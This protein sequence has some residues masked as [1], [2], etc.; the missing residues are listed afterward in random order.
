VTDAQGQVIPGVTV[1]WDTPS[2][3]L[4]APTSLTNNNGVATIEWTL[5]T[6]SGNQTAT[7]TVT[8]VPP[9][10]F[11]VKAVAGPISQIILSRDTVE[12]LGVGDSFRLNARPTDQFGNTVFG[13]ATVESS[14]TSIVT[15]DNFGNG[16]ILTARASNAKT[17]VRATA[18]SVVK[19]GTVV[20]LPPPCQAGST[21][22]NLG[23]GELTVLSGAE[24]SEFCLQGTATGAEFTAIPFFSDMSGSL[25]RV[26]ISTGKTTIGASPNLVAASHF[27]R[28]LG[29]TPSQPSRDEAFE[30]NLREQSRRELTPLMPIARAARRRTGGNFNLLVAVP[31]VGDLLQLNTNSTSGCTNAFV[32]TGRIAAITDRAIV[33]VDTSNPANGF[34]NEDYR[35]FGITFDTLVYPVD[36]QNFGDPTDIDQNAHVI[37]FFTRAVNELTPP[38]QNFYV[39]GFFYGRDLFPKT[40]TGNIAACAASNF[41]EMFYLMVPDP[42]GVVNQNVRTVSFV[43]GVTIGT[44]AHEFQH[45]INSSRHLYVN[46]STEFEDVFL[47]EGLAH[48]AEELNFYH[49]S[50]LSPGQNI[51]FQALQSPQKVLDAFNSFGIAN[52]RRYREFLLSPLINSPYANN[53]NLTTRGATWSF[54]RYAADRRGGNET[55]MWFQLANP[56]AGYRGINNLM[57]VL[58]NDLSSWIRDWATAN[59]AD[60]FVSGIQAVDTDPSWNFRSVIAMMNENQFPLVTQKLDTVS[61]TTVGI[62]DGAAAYLRFGVGP[63]AIGGGRVT[64]RGAPVPSGFSLSIL[65]TK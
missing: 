48:M 17:T 52:I 62:S 38:N 44:L 30:A 58:G 53:A 1:A 3:T 32:R 8:R 21:S 22:L 10:T 64:S 11:T 54:L 18:G 45:L 4:S 24:A 25:L 55:M 59:Y 47:D 50:G 15:A 28:T 26:S 34:T 23:I 12:L 46:G 16:A 7:A 57:R 42:G 43:Q 65:R 31:Q 61:I 6:L 40:T 36:T 27:Q 2:G 13:G 35:S 20:V 29:P 33:V 19:T 5:G 14:D 49:A 9:V 37:L 51:S 41:A 39:G 63:G 60:D 56:P